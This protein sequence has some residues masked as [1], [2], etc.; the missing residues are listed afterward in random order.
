MTTCPNLK[1]WLADE[2]GTLVEHPPTQ[3]ICGL[4]T[5]LTTRS[6]TLGLVRVSEN[7]YLFARLDPYEQ[8]EFAQK[9]AAMVDDQQRPASRPSPPRRMCGRGA[10]EVRNRRNR[11][12]FARKR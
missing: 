2:L 12:Q 6:D 8:M 7:F 9:G 11:P 5:C 3:R 1:Q 4:V 10:R